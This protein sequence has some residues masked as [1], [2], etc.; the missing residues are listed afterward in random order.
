[1]TTKKR[2]FAWML[3][4]ALAANLLAFP[5]SPKTPV[6][7][8]LPLVDDFESGLPAGQD[9]NGI[10][11]GFV[12]FNDA[13][14]TVAISTT[15]SLPEPVPAQGLPDPNHA[16]KMDVSVVAYAGFTHNFENEA[17]DTWVS[18]DW[19]AYEGISF[20]LYGNNSGTTLFVDVLDNRNPGATTDDAERWTIDLPDNFSGWQEIQIPFADMHRKEIG[21]GAPNDGLGLTEVHGWAAVMVTA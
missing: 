20:W 1:M 21:N 13:N 17:L 19:S 4:L 6:A 5:L 14:S 12:T 7:A 2:S 18:Q 9:A 10:P 8:A 3:I 11:V 16:L 15:G